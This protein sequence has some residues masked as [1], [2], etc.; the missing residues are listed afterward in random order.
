VIQGTPADIESGNEKKILEAILEQYKHFS[1]E[2]RLSTR[3]KLLRC[4][5]WQQAVKPGKLLTVF[6]MQALVQDLFSC[7]TPNAAPNGRPTYTSFSKEQIDR[8]F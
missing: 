8:L 3:E 4:V 2:L 7:I 5:A 1:S 6:E